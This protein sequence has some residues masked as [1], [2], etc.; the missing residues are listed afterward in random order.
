M[1]KA[2]G[3]EPGAFVSIQL[4]SPASGDRQTFYPPLLQ[5]RVSIQL[6][7]PASGD[8]YTGESDF[9]SFKW[10]PFNWCPQRVG[11]ASG[12]WEVRENN[13][14]HSIG[15]PSEWGLA[16]HIAHP[17]PE[18]EVS[19]QLVSPAS[20]D[21]FNFCLFWPCLFCFHSIGVPSEW[22]PT[23]AAT[24]QKLDPDAEFPF[25]WCPQRVGTQHPPLLQKRFISVSIQLVSPASGDGQ[26]ASGGLKS[27]P[28]E[29]PFNWCP[30][31]VGTQPWKSWSSPSGC[32]VSIQ[33]VS[34]ASGDWA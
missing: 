11:T 22:G 14:F 1:K 24:M 21:L 28:S 12:L 18:R 8:P 25:N 9:N 26:G 13:G 34:P 15:V 23:I 3:C 10:F 20:G 17:S 29:F 16:G 4:V 5:K 31:R 32:Q 6:V 2:P 33:L 19:I 7:S 30:Q 27:N